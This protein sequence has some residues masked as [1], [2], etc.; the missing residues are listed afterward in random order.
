VHI[1]ERIR[2]SGVDAKLVASI[3]DE[4]QFEVSKKDAKEFGKITKDAMKETERTLDVKCPLD[5]EFKIGTTWMET[6]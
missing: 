5:C 2:K 6:H 4:Y 1:M 3:H